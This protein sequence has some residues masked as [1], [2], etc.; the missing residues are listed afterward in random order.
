MSGLFHQ[1]ETGDGTPRGRSCLDHVRVVA[2]LKSICSS[3]WVVAV[4]CRFLSSAYLSQWNVSSLA[5]RPPCSSQNLRSRSRSYSVIRRVIRAPRRLTDPQKILTVGYL[6][7]DASHNCSCLPIDSSQ[8]RGSFVNSC[9]LSRATESRLRQTP[10][11]TV[12]SMDT[13]ARKS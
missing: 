13:T 3:V 2:T 12:D 11:A 6:E 4:F 8:H 1:H 7:C 10:V 9:W 5:A